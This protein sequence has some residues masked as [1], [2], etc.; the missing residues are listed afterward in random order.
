MQPWMDV[1]PEGWEP[2]NPNSATL[3]D[4]PPDRDGETDEWKTAFDYAAE[5]GN[6]QK[7]AAL[8]ADAHAVDRDDPTGS[9]SRD[10]FAEIGA[11]EAEVARLQAE[12]RRKDAEIESRQAEIQRKGAEISRHK[13]GAKG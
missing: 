6:T 2:P 10:L 3:G 11:K 4:Y 1:T 7:A 5:K 12:I 13:K 9:R 8:Y